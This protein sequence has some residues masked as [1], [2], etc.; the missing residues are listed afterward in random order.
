[1]NAEI[2]AIG[3][4]LLLGE[5]SD[6]NSAHIAKSLRELGLDLW[7]ISAVGDNEARIAELVD[8]ARR[9]STIVITSG[10]LGPTV[11]DPTR[12]AI[13][14]GEAAPLEPLPMLLRQ[15]RRSAKTVR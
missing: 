12:A 11:D 13:A 1:M 6:T 4:E 8:Q 14:R 9:R 15:A 10:G 3:T 5:I 2:I 7:W